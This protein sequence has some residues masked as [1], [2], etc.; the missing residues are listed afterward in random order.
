M[1]RLAQL[2]SDYYGEQHPYTIACHLGVLPHY[3]NL[4]N[5]LRL[6]VEYA[7]RNKAVRLVV[8]TSTL[9]QGVNIP[10]KYLFMIQFYGRT[11][12]Y[13]NS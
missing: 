7:F 5:G 13:A 11:K 6:A 9:A 3:S 10:I 1:S 12:Q 2:M 8:C 4:P